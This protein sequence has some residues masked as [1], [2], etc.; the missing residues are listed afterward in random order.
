VKSIY[1]FVNSLF[2]LLLFSTEMGIYINYS[3]IDLNFHNFHF[4][5]MGY[6]Q[7]LDLG[8]FGYLNMLSIRLEYVRSL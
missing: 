2:V 3:F 6:F 4:L 1:K 8:A 7:I 5:L